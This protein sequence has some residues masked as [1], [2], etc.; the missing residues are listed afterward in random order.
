MFWLQKVVVN[1]NFSFNENCK[2]SLILKIQCCH[3]EGPIP[4]IIHGQGFEQ[5]S[6]PQALFFLD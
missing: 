3:Q 5:N 1:N 4:I 2:Y 6:G